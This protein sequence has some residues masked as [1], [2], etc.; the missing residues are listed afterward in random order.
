MAMLFAPFGCTH[1][2]PPVP[3]F[4]LMHNLSLKVIAGYD[5]TQIKEQK[6]GRSGNETTHNCRHGQLWAPMYSLREG[7]QKLYVLY[8]QLILDHSCQLMA[9]AELLLYSSTEA[10]TC[11]FCDT[12]NVIH[13]HEYSSLRREAHSLSRVHT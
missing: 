6:Q 7:L 3:P 1:P 12:P 5:I 4:L 8:P 13:D 11:G 2:P 10:F 9:L